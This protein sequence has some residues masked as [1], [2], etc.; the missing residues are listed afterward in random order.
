MSRLRLT[1]G[2]FS[3]ALLLVLG[4]AT[5]SAGETKASHDRTTGA[6]PAISHGSPDCET[7]LPAG[8]CV[9]PSWPT[10]PFPIR[11]CDHNPT[12]AFCM[13]ANAHLLDKGAHWRSST[14]YVQ[15]CVGYQCDLLTSAYRAAESSYRSALASYEQCL[16][17]VCTTTTSYAHTATHWVKIDTETCSDGDVELNISTAPK[18]ELRAVSAGGVTVWITVSLPNPWG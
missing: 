5:A 17:P 3:I 18:W 11:I 1:L 6:D 4:V 13:L 2:L 10:A 12:F 8:A 16:R 7:A 15:Y 9:K 14:S